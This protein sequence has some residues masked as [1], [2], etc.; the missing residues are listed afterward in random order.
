MLS[1]IIFKIYLMIS[2]ICCKNFLLVT[3]VS[4]IGCVILEKIVGRV[5]I[6][7]SEESQ[8]KNHDSWY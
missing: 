3:V 5:A 1:C 6:H 7:H 2:M 4:F 8:S